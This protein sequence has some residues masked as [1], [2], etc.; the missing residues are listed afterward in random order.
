MTTNEKCRLQIQRQ[1]D[2][3][4][5]ISMGKKDEMYVNFL[6]EEE[7]DTKIRRV[8]DSD[9]LNDYQR[10]KIRKYFEHLKKTGWFLRF[11]YLDY[12]CAV[13]LDSL[14]RWRIFFKPKNEEVKS[15]LFDHECNCCYCGYYGSGSCR[16]GIDGFP[17]GLWDYTDK[18]GLDDFIGISTLSESEWRYDYFEKR[19]RFKNQYESKI[20]DIDYA[21]KMCKR[22]VDCWIKYQNIKKKKEGIRIP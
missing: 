6:P 5:N 9:R 22:L 16:F 4:A 15:P 20:F 17:L 2:L 13:E 10:T 1:K 12:Q 8:L 3:N 19:K 18:I 14:G 7:L 21:V 11:S